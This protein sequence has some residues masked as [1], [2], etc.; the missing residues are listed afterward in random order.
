[1]DGLNTHSPAAASIRYLHCGQFV[2]ERIRPK[3]SD[4]S[5]GGQF[6]ARLIQ[7]ND[8]GGAEQTEFFQQRLA[9]CGIAGDIRPQQG[10]AGQF[11]FNL[12]IREGDRFHLFAG[13]APIRVKIQHDR[14][15]GIFYGTF[16]LLQVGYRAEDQ[17]I[18]AR[19]GG[20]ADR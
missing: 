3:K 19:F 11:L 20:L 17:I 7:H 13:R 5:G 1:M 15:G 2:Q 16:Q 9:R 18:F 12:L 4:H 6:I 8:R 14:L 10:V